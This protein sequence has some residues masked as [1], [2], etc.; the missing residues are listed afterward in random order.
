MT[1]GFLFEDGGMV[2]FPPYIKSSIED[3]NID[4]VIPLHILCHVTFHYMCQSL[5]RHGG[6]LFSIT[7]TEFQPS[8]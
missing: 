8:P 3:K 1:H 7:V 6:F 4:M 2:G 5:N